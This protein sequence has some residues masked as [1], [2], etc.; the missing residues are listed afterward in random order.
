MTRKEEIHQSL[1]NY[2][3]TYN[4]LFPNGCINENVYIDG[5]EWAD[6]TMI[7]KACEWLEENLWDSIKTE[8]IENFRK[9]MEK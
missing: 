9:A 8:F 2:K 1:L 4:A 6:K 5:A 7:D 3:N